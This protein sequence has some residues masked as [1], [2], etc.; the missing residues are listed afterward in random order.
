MTSHNTDTDQTTTGSRVGT[1][2]KD[3]AGNEADTQKNPAGN[4]LTPDERKADGDDDAK[5]NPDAPQH[6]GFARPV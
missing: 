5:Q 3:P 1:G 4:V 6:G 2:E